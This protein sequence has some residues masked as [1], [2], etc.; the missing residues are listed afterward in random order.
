M[1]RI[2][3]MKLR[4]PWRASDFFQHAEDLAV[5]IRKDLRAWS[6]DEAS[7]SASKDDAERLAHL[8]EILARHGR[9]QTANAAS[10]IAERLEGLLNLLVNEIDELLSSGR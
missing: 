3:R 8:V 1:K 7:G 5:Q 9:S 4:P 10:E 6:A 2:G